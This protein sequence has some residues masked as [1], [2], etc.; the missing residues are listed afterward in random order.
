[1][2]ERTLEE[3][4]LFVR[5]GRGAEAHEK[6]SALTLSEVPRPLIPKLANIAR[7]V[8]DPTLALRALSP[9]IRSTKGAVDPPQELEKAEYAAAL[10]KVGAT[11]EALEI[12]EAVNVQEV[13]KAYF[14]KALAYFTQWRYEEAVPLLRAYL[15]EESLESFD[16]LMGQVNLAAALVSVGT[17]SE[18]DPLLESIQKEAILQ[19]EFLVYG[20]CIELAAQSALAKK[21]YRAAQ[22]R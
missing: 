13:P 12:L 7:R 5:M 16:R 18:A 15:S 9:Y 1:L 2:V 10:T 8:G 22:Y 20:Y 21:E 11:V 14:Y 6:L 17:Y 4:D 19:R 3:L